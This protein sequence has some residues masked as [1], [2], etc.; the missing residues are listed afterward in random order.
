MLQR[1]RLVVPLGEVAHHRQRVLRG[2]RGR[3]AGQAVGGVHVVAAHHDHRHAVAPGVVERH[4]GVLHADRAVEQQAHRLAGDLGVAV[5]H[6][7]AALLVQ[8]GEN[9]GFLFGVGP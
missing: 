8:H 9:S 4:R 3:H 5:R 1:D 2:V 6:A 7:G